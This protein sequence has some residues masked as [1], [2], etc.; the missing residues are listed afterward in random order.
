MRSIHDVPNERLLWIFTKGMEDE[1]DYSWRPCPRRLKTFASL[2]R[3]VCRHWR[4]LIDDPFQIS[5]WI[6][7]STVRMSV[8]GTRPSNRAKSL[9]EGLAKFRATL[10][11]SEKCDL[12]ITFEVG[13]PSNPGQEAEL[14]LML[15]AVDMLT[16]Y[17][18]QIVQI[19]LEGGQTD[20]VAHLIERITRWKMAQR[21][22]DIEFEIDSRFL[23]RWRNISQSQ[24]RPD[25]MQLGIPQSRSPTW[26]S[27]PTVA[28]MAHFENLD[29]LKIP[30]A[31]WL[32]DGLI[33]PR[34][35]HHLTISY[36][37]AETLPI[38]Y[39]YLSNNDCDHLRSIN[40]GKAGVSVVEEESVSTA[41]FARRSAWKAKGSLIL[42]QLLELELKE[43]AE[44]HLTS[45]LKCLFCPSLEILNLCWLYSNQPPADLEPE[46]TAASLRQPLPDPFES[47]SVM[48]PT[49]H[50]CNSVRSRFVSIGSHLHPVRLRLS[51]ISCNQTLLNLISMD[52]LHLEDLY[53]NMMNST[54]EQQVIEEWAVRELTLHHRLSAPSLTKL[55]CVDITPR[56]FMYFLTFLSAPNLL[57][58]DVYPVDEELPADYSESFQEHCPLKPFPSVEILHYQFSA[59]SDIPP[60]LL[61]SDFFPNL[62]ELRIEYGDH[63][64][65]RVG[66]GNRPKYQDYII[67][68]CRS[69]GPT[70]QSSVPFPNLRS[71]HV[72][73]ECMGWPGRSKGDNPDSSGMGLGF[74]DAVMQ[75]VIDEVLMSRIRLGALPL[76]KILLCPYS[77][78]EDFFSEVVTYIRAS[79]DLPMVDE[80]E[81]NITN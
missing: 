48:P 59:P 9:A 63:D 2:T 73:C 10:F 76:Y 15:H 27:L 42:P 56:A 24:V 66:R 72:Q 80:S 62:R 6:A 18:Q 49:A 54:R 78:A 67:S 57:S 70:I 11:T 47:T 35:L 34:T 51:N 32:N 4:T 20:I 37:D 77:K 53:A 40:V 8:S 81:D 74:H 43:A 13:I 68:L 41:N 39:Q 19:R 21:L 69:L 31:S 7:R 26:L 75:S 17:E 1:L 36:V 12:S 44:G 3:N 64:E 30:S 14:R 55:E 23:A 52:T 60:I 5:F 71:L 50:G 29:R 58:V 45:L 28:S 65:E 61:L 46:V 22:V 16:P 25:F 38:L 33:L 79:S